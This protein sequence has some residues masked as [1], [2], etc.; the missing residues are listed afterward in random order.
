MLLSVICRKLCPDGIAMLVSFEGKR[1]VA[2]S[3]GK[4]LDDKCGKH[5]PS[6]ITHISGISRVHTKLNETLEM[7]YSETAAAE[8]EE[9]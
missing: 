4:S 5:S 9:V 2:V 7:D 3:A 8:L 6:C 1:G